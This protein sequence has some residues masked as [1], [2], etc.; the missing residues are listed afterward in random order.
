MSFLLDV[1]LIYFLIYMFIFI[2]VFIYIPTLYFNVHP[3]SLTVGCVRLFKEIK[4]FM[5]GISRQ[6]IR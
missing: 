1:F 3:L 4:V 5:I 2:E 6:R